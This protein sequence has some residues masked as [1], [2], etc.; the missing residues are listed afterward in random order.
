MMCAAIVGDLI[1]LGLVDVSAIVSNGISFIDA[2]RRN[3]NLRLEYNN[4]GGGYF[5]KI[6]TD[7][8]KRLAL[9]H[10]ART[11]QLLRGV[12]SASCAASLPQVHAF[13]PERSMLVLQMLDSRT[14]GT[15]YTSRPRSAPRFIGM[16]GRAL[17][18]IHRELEMNGAIPE[19]SEP[20]CPVP[21]ELWR[22]SNT[23]LETCSGANLE[24]LKI[25]QRS[26]R[27]C[28]S[29]RALVSHWHRI[30]ESKPQT[31][32]GDVRLDNCCMVADRNSIR[33]VDW[34]LAGKGDPNWDVGAVFA[35]LLSGWLMSIPPS[36][37]PDPA[38]HAHLAKTPRDL[39][40][41]AARAFWIAYVEG[42]GWT[43]AASMEALHACTRY[44][45]ARLIQLAFE[46]LQSGSGVTP[47]AIGHLQLCDNLLDRPVDG[48]ALLLGLAA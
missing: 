37:G 41:A 40:K 7:P 45:A 38:Q 44:A 13:D 12:L 34:E 5:I 6:G 8:S 3:C 11:Y 20:F 19:G 22:P 27:L 43:P 10:E 48:A 28:R 16:L 21:F 2:S 46:H 9:A 39:V 15:I 33:I 47:Y 18:G 31:I 23:F 17:G 30:V 26:A 29:L 36:A 1:G 14:A 4:G 42:R 35:D 25:I 24:F 32:H